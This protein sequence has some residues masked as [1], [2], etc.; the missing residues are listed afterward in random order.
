MMR[1]ILLAVVLA[2]ALPAAQAE[3]DPACSGDCAILLGEGGALQVQARYAEAL[4][5]FKAAAAAAPAAS[6]PHAMAAGLFLDMS[7]TSV[8]AE[9]RGMREK[10]AML[11]RDALQRKADDPLALEVLRELADPAPS[12]LREANAEAR[13]RIDEAELLFARRDYPAALAK[14]QEAMVLDPQFSRAWVGAGDCWFMQHDWARAAPLFQRATEIEP[15]NSQAWRFLADALAEQGKLA[16]AERALLSGIAADPGQLP[17][18]NKLAKL[19]SVIGTPLK[20]LGLQ[21]A[22]LRTGE[23]GKPQIVFADSL[24]KSSTSF[25]NRVRIAL[26]AGAVNPGMSASGFRPTSFAV[27]LAAWQLALRAADEMSAKDGDKP[28]DPALLAMQAMARDGQLEP[29]IF[30]L[31]YKESYR[32]EYERWLAAH[33][34]GVQAF[35]ERYALRP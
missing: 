33:P 26:A 30:V 5:K 8:P 16:Q 23:N 18:W 32:P 34:D 19:R 1:K 3:L 25:D 15:R 31:L 7:K 17:N 10:A 29:A 9:A 28:S 27:E 13:K 22:G 4:A 35:I 21:R 11:A 24:L 2:L 20:P 6:A 12:P 14:Y